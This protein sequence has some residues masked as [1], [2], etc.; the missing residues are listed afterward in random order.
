M[1]R[2]QRTQLNKR[3]GTEVPLGK[4]GSGRTQTVNMPAVAPV[5]SD[6]AKLAEA[7]G[8]AVEAGG[9]VYQTVQA[10]DAAQAKKQAADHKA[11]VKQK[12]QADYFSHIETLN[13]LS[14]DSERADLVKTIIYKASTVGD[15]EYTHALTA[16]MDGNFNTYLKGARTEYLKNTIEPGFSSQVSSSVLEKG[17]IDYSSIASWADGKDGNRALYHDY[18]VSGLTAAINLKASE[19]STQEELN[20]F[21]E[22]STSVMNDYKANEFLGK[23]KSNQAVDLQTKINKHLAMSIEDKSSSVIK[24][25]KAS[26]NNMK[27]N[28]THPAKVWDKLVEGKDTGMYSNDYIDTEIISYGNSWA[29]K[30][31]KIYTQGLTAEEKQIEASLDVTTGQAYVNKN[32]QRVLEQYDQL[33]VKQVNA[34]MISEDEHQEALNQRIQTIKKNREII[35]ISSGYNVNDNNN[36]AYSLYKPH[37]K[38]AADTKIKEALEEAS[39]IIEVAQIYRNNKH[40]TA[41]IDGIKRQLPLTDDPAAINDAFAKYNILLED[42]D[43]VEVIGALPPKTRLF[44]NEL[45]MLRRATGTDAVDEIEL[46]VAYDKITEH[47][48]AD[49]GIKRKQVTKL[50]ELTNAN[51]EA[52]PD[53][54]QNE[55]AAVYDFYT[56]TRSASDAHEAT[57]SYLYKYITKDT[58]EGGLPGGFFSQAY[59]MSNFIKGPNTLQTKGSTLIETLHSAGYTQIQKAANGAINFVYDDKRKSLTVDDG[60][61]VHYI[62]PSAFT[63]IFG[64]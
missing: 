19:V 32:E 5:K 33:L 48:I 43:R 52:L 41:A 40:S 26:I 44:Y 9:K 23:S 8:M 17:K 61:T 11:R 29:D 28:D 36:E 47:S 63:R 16:L 38:A 58:E 18:T 2:E 35:D 15:P 20:I 12:A 3:R 21:K 6:G 57:Q 1:P 46:K 22:W 27:A 60:V 30:E 37:E 51:I 42:P 24:A 31:L 4:Y 56:Q 62:N 50:Q 34:S 54:L 25:H 10:Q 55:L 64:N 39:D 45:D 13:G 49:L 7:F 53:D 59:K 14:S